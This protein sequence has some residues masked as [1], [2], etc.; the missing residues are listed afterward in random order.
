MTIK[1]WLHSL[2]QF[3]K[4][5]DW[6]ESTVIYYMQANLSGVA[7]EWYDNLRG[8]RKIWNEWKAALE[9]NFPET[10]DHAVDLE[11]MRSRRK[12]N[13]ESY[14]ESGSDYTMMRKRI[15]QELNLQVEPKCIC[16]HGYGNVPSEWTEGL[17]RVL[18][19]LYRC[20]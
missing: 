3:K 7:R 2:E 12:L 20:C 10:R 15:V 1:Q 8:Y 13:G 14:K 19:L 6:P 18:L 4:I 5:F 16:I 17:I 9:A 11:R